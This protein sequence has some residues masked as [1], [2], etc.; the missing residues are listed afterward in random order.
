MKAVFILSIFVDIPTNVA[1]SWVSFSQDCC[2]TVEN[3][4]HC[5]FAK[6]SVRQDCDMYTYTCRTPIEQQVCV[7]FVAGL[8]ILLQ[9]NFKHFH[10]S[11]RK[12]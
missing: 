5:E 1:N 6:I 3:F 10:N 12:W 9:T 8:R 2:V 7:N 4:S 11:F